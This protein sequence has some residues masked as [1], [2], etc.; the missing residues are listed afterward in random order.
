M[1]HSLVQRIRVTILDSLLGSSLVLQTTQGTILD[2]LH[3]ADSLLG[4]SLRQVT[5]LVT[6]LVQQPTQV[7]TLGISLALTRIYMEV[8]LLGITRAHT[9]ERILVQLYSPRKTPYQLLNCGLGLHNY[10]S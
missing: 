6:M 4:S 9:Q 10:G 2:L 5:I 3:T 8:T 7:T 1:P